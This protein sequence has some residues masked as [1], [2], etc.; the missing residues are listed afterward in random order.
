MDKYKTATELIISE[1]A[2][3]KSDFYKRVV[4]RIIKDFP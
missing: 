3:G 1:I 4:K 2:K